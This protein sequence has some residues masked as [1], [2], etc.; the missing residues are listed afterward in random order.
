[1]LLL[2]HKCYLMLQLPPIVESPLDKEQ[3]DC[4]TDVLSIIG[5]ETLF[6][7]K[8]RYRAVLFVNVTIHYCENGRTTVRKAQQWQWRSD[9]CRHIIESR[10]QSHGLSLTS[11][12]K[13]VHALVRQDIRFILNVSNQDIQFG[14]GA[15]ASADEFLSVFIKWLGHSPVTCVLGK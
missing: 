1:M 6:L 7:F 5:Q 14:P 15:A 12:W 2:R 9:C 4:L 10:R 8:R 11:W 13:V 3:W